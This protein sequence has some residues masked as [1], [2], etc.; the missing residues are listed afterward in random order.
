MEKYV[1]WRIFFKVINSQIRLWEEITCWER[2]GADPHWLRNE[3]LVVDL[4]P[5][6]VGYVNPMHDLAE[7]RGGYIECETYDIRQF[8]LD[9]LGMLGSGT[10]IPF[11]GENV[12]IRADVRLLESFGMPE[13]PIF[14]LE[15]KPFPE[16]EPPPDEEWFIPPVILT[17]QLRGVP[18]QPR[19][20]KIYWEI[21]GWQNLSGYTFALNSID[22]W[23]RVRVHQAEGSHYNTSIFQF[24]VD[25]IPLEYENYKEA[26][27][28]FQFD[29]YPQRLLIGGRP[30]GNGDILPLFGDIAYLEF[31]PNDSCRKCL[32]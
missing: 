2:V 6:I 1:F 30:D 5:Q 4:Q 14:Y 29:P 24:W 16:D 26:P 28:T 19:V 11:D 8:Q 15:Q 12:S 21:G 9:C 18:N 7:F 13:Y 31:D 27:S 25:T 20:N 22:D 10:S 3:R 23:H 17:E 32:M